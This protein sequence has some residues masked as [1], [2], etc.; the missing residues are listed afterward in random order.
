MIN[1]LSKFSTHLSE[2]TEPIRDLAKER[3]PFNWGLEHNEAFSLIKKELTAAPI[4]AYYNPKKLMVLQDR[5]QLQRARSVPL[6]KRKAGVLHQQSI[7]RN[8]EGLLGH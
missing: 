2:L 5:W 1:Y 8:P 3:V 6:T 7:N 4:L